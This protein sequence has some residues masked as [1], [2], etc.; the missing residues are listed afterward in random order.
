L[1]FCNTLIN[2]KSEIYVLDVDGRNIVNIT[3]Q[4]GYGWFASW[5][6]DGRYIAFSTN[7]NG[8][9]DIFVMKNDGTEQTR[10][11]GIDG[12]HCFNPLS[13]PVGY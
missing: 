7:R 6:P 9:Y 8:N 2:D 1:E 11:V 3:E 12:M 5:S 10:I 13:S 4:V